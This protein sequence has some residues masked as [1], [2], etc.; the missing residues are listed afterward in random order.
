[1]VQIASKIPRSNIFIFEN[2]WLQ[3]PGFFELIELHWKNSAIFGNAAKNLANKLK[4]IRMAIGTWRKSLSN[5]SKLIHNSNWVL[6]LLDGLED[7]RPLSRLEHNFRSLVK[8]HLSKLLESKRFYWKRRNTVRWVKLV[9]EN[10]SF[11]HV[12]ATISH[13]RNFI[14]SLTDPD[15]NSITNHDQ[16]ANMLWVA[17]K[18]RMG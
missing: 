9:D 7:Q 5:L 2:F 12:M 1:V 17:F 15:D 4:Q 10:T 6:A 8:W 13:K 14:V 18:Q 3:H 16:K 11:F